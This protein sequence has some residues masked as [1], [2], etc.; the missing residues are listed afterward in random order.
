MLGL[1]I[2]SKTFTS[3]L[4]IFFMQSLT[5][6]VFCFNCIWYSTSF[7]SQLPQVFEYG[8]FDFILYFEAS[9]TS[10]KFAKAKFLFIFVILIFTLS[11]ITP[12]LTKTGKP[13]KR[14]SDFPSYNIFSISTIICE[15]MVKLFIYIIL[16]EK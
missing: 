10:T 16:G 11:P 15:F 5:I 1:L 6:S 7:Q 8:Q 3:S 12:P 13:L 14:H 4:S 2:V 9:T